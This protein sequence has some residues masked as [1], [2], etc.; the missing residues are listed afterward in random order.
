[1]ETGGREKKPIRLNIC[2][3]TISLVTSEDPAE[4]EALAHSV[5][6][7]IQGI[8]ARSGNV[9]LT[10]VAILACLHLADRLNSLEQDLGAL[11]KRVERKSEEFAGLLDQALEGE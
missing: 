10:R 11:K 6:E 1:M 2:N 9:E 5:D 8:A 3:H 7:L 4:L